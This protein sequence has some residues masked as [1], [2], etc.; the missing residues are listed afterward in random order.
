MNRKI[1]IFGFIILNLLFFCF[2]KNAELTPEQIALQQKLKEEGYVFKPCSMMTLIQEKQNNI[3]EKYLKAGYN[4]NL[5]CL[6]TSA[7]ESA[8]IDDNPEAFKLFIEYGADINRKSLGTNLL[9][10]AILY[11]N[12][13]IAQYLYEKNIKYSPNFEKDLQFLIGN[14][15]E[16]TNTNVVSYKTLNPNDFY[17]IVDKKYTFIPLTNEQKTSLTK[18]EM[19]QY[20][21]ILKANKELENA[22]ITKDSTLKEKY[23][24][25]ALS[26]CQN[27]NPALYEL[28]KHYYFEKK[29]S[30]SNYYLNKYL[31]IN[32]NKALFQHNA[33]AM[34]S[35]N[36]FFLK[37][38][39]TALNIAKETHEKYQ[40]NFN[41]KMA[42]YLLRTIISESALNIGNYN[43][44]IEY[45]NKNLNAPDKKFIENSIAIKYVAYAKQ[46]K[47]N[48]AH[49][50]AKKLIK[51]KENYINYIRLA[52]TTNNSSEKLKYYYNAKKFANNYDEILNCMHSIAS[53]ES[54]KIKK[55]VSS[56]G[57]YTKTPDWYEI[58]AL[59]YSFGS[60]KYWSLRQDNF[61]NATNNCINKYT[62]KNL[63]A[64][65][66]QVL[67]DEEIKTQHLKIEQMIA[68]QQ[69]A[70]YLRRMTNMY[71]S[72]ISY[73]QQMANYY[74][75]ETNSYLRS[76]NNKL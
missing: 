75:S 31:E 11:K 49:Q 4:P 45:A 28:G 44:A 35:Y 70:N 6:G 33:M 72:E 5:T 36:Y 53:L 46:N 51:T 41:N 74:Q 22:E 71:L 26:Y 9:E 24:L 58:V 15:T 61:Y 32:S 73:Q 66:G 60:I 34:I 40:N 18:E 52:S 20:K 57:F 1:F 16:T 12:K 76:I 30:D 63:S 69:E 29:Y 38:Y 23:Y 25:K 54:K 14:K 55:A 68:N 42:T 48:L 2:A 37:D 67:K 13:E 62:G 17:K 56:L 7:T 39:K 47:L 59:G 3:I 64:C 8:I 10:H 43:L 19:K 50:E 65:F 27:L 21:K